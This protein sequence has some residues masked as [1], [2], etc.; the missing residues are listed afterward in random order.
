MAA[1]LPGG[2]AGPFLGVGCGTDSGCMV[3]RVCPAFC[4]GRCVL[5]GCSCGFACGVGCVAIWWPW[6]FC[7]TLVGA[8][9]GCMGGTL[10]VGGRMGACMGTAVRCCTLFGGAWWVY[11][12][13]CSCC[14][15]CC[16]CRFVVVIGL[17]CGGKYDAAYP[18]A[19]GMFPFPYASGYSYCESVGGCAW[20]GLSKGRCGGNWMYPDPVTRVGS[21]FMFCTSVRRWH[22]PSVFPAR[23]V[24]FDV[25]LWSAR[26][27][28][29][30]LV[31]QSLPTCSSTSN[32][33]WVC[34][35]K[36]LS[37][38]SILPLLPR[39]HSHVPSLL[40]VSFV[41][42]PSHLDPHRGFVDA[43]LVGPHAL[44]HDV[45][46]PNP[47]TRKPRTFSM[48]LPP[49]P[50]LGVLQDATHPPPLHQPS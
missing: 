44:R 26:R 22:R 10:C 11:R 29:L 20:T 18:C 42:F 31:V 49:P 8:R 43:I 32:S 15:C 7:N 45:V 41:R 36:V 50:S 35:S 46:G 30:V 16:G 2:L 9:V 5:Y 13:C 27:L 4:I 37:L 39:V 40:S 1:V 48:D 25:Y 33:W 24:S 6:F 47:T 12:G 23:F 28:S 17:V 38:V 3:G 14:C 21:C 34:P 19:A